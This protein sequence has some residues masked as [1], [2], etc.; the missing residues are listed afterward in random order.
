MTEPI[1]PVTTALTGKL[2]FYLLLAAVLTFPLA[3]G[4]LQLYARAVRRSM[5]SRAHGYSTAAAAR[6]PDAPLSAPGGSQ[7]DTRAATLYDLSESAPNA[8]GD[9]LLARLLSGPRRAA[10]VYAAAGGAYGMLMAAA[11]LLAGGLEI[12][13]VRFLMLAW[14]FSWP[15]VLTVGIVAATT[16]RAKALATAGYFL[17]LMAIG[18]VAMSRSPDLTW[19]QVFI[20]WL[21]YDLPPTVLLLTF[22]SRRI[23]AVGPLIL[24]FMLLA[25]TGSDVVISMVGS[26]G[27][28]VRAVIDITSPLGLGA[29]GTF[30]ALLA[31]GFLMFSVLGWIAL[32]WIG[33]RYQAKKISDE[34]VTVD[35]VWIVFA[36]VH[37]ID[38]VFGHPLWMLGGVAAFAAYKTV[39]RI[40]FSWLGGVKSESQQRPTL[41]VLRSFSIGH[42]SERL[43]DVVGRYW[44]RV[45]SIQ[46]IAGVDL[47]SRTL[48]PHEFLDLVS[49]RLSR[50]FIDGEE[51]LN[52]RI[53]ERD[54]APDR[55]LRFRV[56]EFFCY[57]DTWKMVLSRLVHESDVVV[58]D[59]R[60]FS[61]QNAGCVFELHELAR[62]VPLERVVFVTDRRTDETLLAET[63][64]DHRAGV[65]RLGSMAGS[66]VRHLMRAMAGAASATSAARDPQLY[67]GA[68]PA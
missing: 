43:F 51:S 21:M 1:D 8:S 16:R 40:G 64:G 41:L 36:I 59:L 52:R 17:V 5:G 63:L 18:A 57:D 56:N 66:R 38:L 27:R 19:P 7:A 39:V 4:V 9:T 12:L 61:R 68:G 13:P 55:D 24:T 22:L 30:I 35:A 53:S 33:R 37:S 2:P 45:G 6:A 31:V 15:V 28:Y 46:M 10:L 32:L 20:P 3:W 11:Q 67:L 26:Q 34:S 25:L 49:G 58:M 14:M 48:E 65:F 50:R 29:T 47:V 23:R 54:T 42:D 44:R 60:G 62:L